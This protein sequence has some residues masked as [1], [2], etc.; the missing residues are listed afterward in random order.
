M[1]L[2]RFKLIG[3]GV[4]GIVITCV[5]FIRGKNNVI[6]KDDV[7]RTRKVP[8]PHKFKQSVAKL[9]YYFLVLTGHWIEPFNKYYDRTTH[10]IAPIPETGVVPMGQTILIELMN[11]VAI[12]GAL[13]TGKGFLLTGTIDSYGDKTI[14][15]STRIVT[16][17]DDAGFYNE[18]HG[19]LMSIFTDVGVFFKEGMAIEDSPKEYLTDLG[20]A[21]KE[22]FNDLSEEELMNRVLDA[23]QQRGGIILM[24]AD[25]SME[26]DSPVNDNMKSIEATDTKVTLDTRTGSI[27]GK[28]LEEVGEKTELENK[29]IDKENDQANADNSPKEKKHKEST[30]VDSDREFPPDSISDEDI[31][32]AVGPVIDEVIE[33]IVPPQ[34]VTKKKAGS[35]LASEKDF[36]AATGEQAKEDVP[37]D[38]TGAEFSEGH[39][40]EVD[41]WNQEPQHNG[42]DEADLSSADMEDATQSQQ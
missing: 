1:K 38:L 19:V 8:F 7:T 41:D 11:K 37:V 34:K 21:E 2:E 10:T 16:E 31:K 13:F 40:P 35:T 22:G 14:G 18:A 5:E 36:A 32:A 4:G 25:G 33:V 26:L 3:G 30:P 23:F 15:I 20:Y 27:D 6:F 42:G 39:N 17:E 12:T 28:H 29:E 9:K 24:P